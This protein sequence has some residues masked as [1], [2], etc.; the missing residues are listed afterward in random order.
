MDRQSLES[1]LK[2]ASDGDENAFHTLL[3][4]PPSL[5]PQL[6]EQY[7]REDNPRTRAVVVEV[8]WQHRSPEVVSFLADALSDPAAEVWKQAID[9]LVTIGDSSAVAALRNWKDLS[10]SDDS[11]K[12]DSRSS[13][14][15]EA[16]EQ[17]NSGDP[18]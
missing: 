17:L 10:A 4:A 11:T 18:S 7:S 3:E 8:V 12:A 1:L 14:I 5:I 6:I 9:G 2:V 13:W 15:A 16:L